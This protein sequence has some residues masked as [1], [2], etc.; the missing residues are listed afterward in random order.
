[1]IP[2]FA[3]TR[4]GRSDERQEWSS[5][6]GLIIGALEVSIPIRACACEGGA[7]ENLASAV[8]CLQNLGAKRCDLRT[9]LKGVGGEGRVPTT[10]LAR[11]AGAFANHGWEGG[12][13]FR[14]PAEATASFSFGG[15]APRHQGPGLHRLP[16]RYLSRKSR[17]ARGPSPHHP[18]APPCIAPSTR[19]S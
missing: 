8:P 17:T 7:A 16:K 19:T 15:D 11:E 13:P 9:A 10:P 1:M 2:A 5:H 18:V 14:L 12:S 6:G 4:G 3:F